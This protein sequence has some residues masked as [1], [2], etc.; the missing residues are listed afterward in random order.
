M[1]KKIILVIFSLIF[2][3]SCGTAVA[4]DNNKKVKENIEVAV[5]EEK[6]NEVEEFD[7]EI[8]NVSGSLVKIYKNIEELDNDSDFGIEG[9]VLSN[10]YMRYKDVAFTISTVKVEKSLKGDI[11]EGS[12][13]RVL[14]TGGIVDVTNEN[15]PEKAFEDKEE[16]AISK[17]RSKGKKVEIVFENAPVLKTNQKCILY[18]DKYEGPIGE[19]LYVAEGDFQG[20]FKVD[21]SGKVEAQSDRIED[22]PETAIEL[23]K[24]IAE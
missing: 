23:E 13:I 2:L 15:L 22:V 17:E 6:Q 20:R 21:N 7:Y 19:D 16:V 9:T 11:T 24:E 14:Q 8:I 10:E 3:A 12:T 1:N 4:L 5:A 18:L